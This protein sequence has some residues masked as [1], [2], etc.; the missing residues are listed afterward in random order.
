MNLKMCHILDVCERCENWV[1]CLQLLRPRRHKVNLTAPP[2]FKNELENVKV[3]YME[4]ATSG[5]N[6]AL[7]FWDER[8][9]QLLRFHALTWI[10]QVS[11]LKLWQLGL[12][13]CEK[14]CSIKVDSLS[15]QGNMFFG[16]IWIAGKFNLSSLFFYKFE[17]SPEISL[18]KKSSSAQ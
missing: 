15:S 11:G 8:P 18:L 12:A 3:H 10:H 16:E 9:S 14:R 5:F 4:Y 2:L 6:M 1:E 17:V 13:I 7:L